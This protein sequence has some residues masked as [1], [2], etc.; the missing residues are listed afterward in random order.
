LFRGYSRRAAGSAP[1]T[2]DVYGGGQSEVVHRPAGPG[3]NG[4]GLS[5]KH[6]LASID[7]V[8][9]ARRSPVQVALA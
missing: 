4:A 9:G 7:E 8:A 6:I 5:R 1:R 3:E 2:A